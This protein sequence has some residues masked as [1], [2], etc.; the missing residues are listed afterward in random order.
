MVSRAQDGPRSYAREACTV[1]ALDGL[2]DSERRW[3][4]YTSKENV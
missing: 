3:L 2:N 4:A 1:T